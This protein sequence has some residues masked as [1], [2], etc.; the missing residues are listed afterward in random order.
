MYYLT[1]LGFD[2]P[3]RDHRPRSRVLFWYNYKLMACLWQWFIE[4]HLFLLSTPA[5]A[6]AAAAR[7]Q[8]RETDIKF[9]NLITAH[10]MDENSSGHRHFYCPTFVGQ[11]VGQSPVE[12]SFEREAKSAPTIENNAMSGLIGNTIHLLWTSAGLLSNNPMATENKLSGPSPSNR[13][14]DEN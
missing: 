5:A 8:D 13:G 4:I 12:W 11:D 14:Q 10:N 7:P 9:A 1:E 2:S 3:P 6:A